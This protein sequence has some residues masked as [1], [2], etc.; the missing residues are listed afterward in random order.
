MSG[1]AKAALED[2]SVAG[3]HIWHG[4]SEF[5]AS[6]ATENGLGLLV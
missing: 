2:A 5:R 4:A 1:E 6:K 3:G